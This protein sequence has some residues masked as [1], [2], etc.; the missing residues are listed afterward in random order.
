[1]SIQKNQFADVPVDSHITERAA[2]FIE[3]TEI[4]T[5]PEAALSIAKRCIL[6]G[7][8]LYV[9]GS[10]HET[11]LILAELAEE[12]GGKAEALL[13]GKGTVKV[14]A[15]MAARVLSWKTT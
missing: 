6:D 9:A 3:T 5:I 14:P 13:L 4:T 11:T 8:G 12:Q 15:A 10:N 2:N 7:L 1:M